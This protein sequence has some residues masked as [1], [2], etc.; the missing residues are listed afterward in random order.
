MG[1]YKNNEVINQ[2][3][4]K[5]P[6][7][8]QE[9]LKRYIYKM[10]RVYGSIEEFQKVYITNLINGENIV[11][12][13]LRR[14]FV[15]Y[16]DIN[17]PD[18]V[19]RE[20]FE[21]MQLLE[22]IYE[23]SGILII[24][25]ENSALMWQNIMKKLSLREQDVVIKHFG[26][27]GKTE[28]LSEIA[29]EYNVTKE[30]IRQIEERSILK[31][32]EEKCRK[33]FAPFVE[34]VIDANRE[35]EIVR[36]FFKNNG[37]FRDDSKQ[38]INNLPTF[39]RLLEIAMAEQTNRLKDANL[40]MNLAQIKRAR[41]IDSAFQVSVE[42]KKLKYLSK[43]AKNRYNGKEIIYNEDVV[44]LSQDIPKNVLMAIYKQASESEAAKEYI[45]KLKRVKGIIK[46]HPDPKI[47]E[48][49]TL[50]EVG[51]NARVSK[52]LESENIKTLSDL[53]TYSMYELKQIKSLS[54]NSIVSIA[55]VL[56]KY[57]FAIEDNEIEQEIIKDKLT[58][59]QA[60]KVNIEEVGFSQR[61]MLGLK[62]AG[63]NTL[64]DL[65][66]YSAE[67]ILN[68]K[69]IGE[70]CIEEIIF[71]LNLRGLKL[72]DNEKAK[73]NNSI[74]EKYDFSYFQQPEPEQDDN[75]SEAYIIALQLFDEFCKP[76]TTEIDRIRIKNE[77]Q[78]LFKD[79][80]ECEALQI[81]AKIYKQIENIGKECNKGEK[82]E[83]E[84][85][86][87][88]KRKR[89]AKKNQTKNDSRDIE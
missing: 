32:R 29:G 49:P 85:K 18:F 3:V 89:A 1:R 34:D 33:I 72:E 25:S 63:I 38:T 22:K 58:K 57:G 15:C 43:R 77:I 39:E 67:E 83:I 45:N 54:K 80:D 53:L 37:I 21:Y 36:Q 28:T 51:I 46:N 73:K 50:E 27:Y 81:R 82:K 78:S 75:P 26:L 69:N 14:A 31:L 87:A 62:R 17:Q 56:H 24:N 4:E 7:N 6:Q 55:L 74:D 10:L 52:I 68:I 66:N 2:I 86:P 9:E 16:L 60:K 41:I 59:K 88:S 84:K 20:Q 5:Q 79:L 19:C 47:K 35:A 76:E 71:A 44:G 42:V 70:K 48:N 13:N 23:N 65:I 12:K 11:P 30:C 40:I 61:V 8:I 64:G